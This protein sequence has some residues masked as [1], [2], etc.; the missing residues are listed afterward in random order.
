MRSM[1]GLAA[2][3]IVLGAVKMSVS[4]IVPLLMA[5]TLTV[6][7]QPLARHIARLGWPPYISAIITASAVPSL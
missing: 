1:V 7:F 5:A 6:A 3:V 4:L 2:L